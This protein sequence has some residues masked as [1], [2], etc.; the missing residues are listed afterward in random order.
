V[1]VDGKSVEEALLQSGLARIAYVY[2]PN[3][4]YLEQYKVIENESKQKKMGIWQWDGYV[5]KD[6][7]HKEV[8]G[9]IKFVSSKNSKVYYPSSC[10][11]VERIKLKNRIY[12]ISEQE[13][14]ASGRSRTKTKE[15][16]TSK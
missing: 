4:K 12:F 7:F 8:V 13:A 11:A 10:A 6:G 3:I 1:Y 2:P 5:Q 14:Q 15:C 9:G 16:W